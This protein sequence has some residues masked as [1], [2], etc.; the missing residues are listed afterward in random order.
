MFLSNVVQDGLGPLLTLEEKV[1]LSV[2]S[3]S[4]YR[5]L[6]QNVGWWNVIQFNG[7][8]SQIRLNDAQLSSLLVRTGMVA[9]FISL[10]GCTNINGVGLKP[11]MGSTRLK[12]VD[13]RSHRLGYLTK[14]IDCNVSDLTTV[15]HILRSSP[16]VQNVRLYWQRTPKIK[17]LFFEHYDEP[18]RGFM[19][20]LNAR[21]I[22]KYKGRMCYG[23]A[24]T[25]V[26]HDPLRHN[27]ALMACGQ[28]DIVYCGK[29][30][31]SVH[32]MQCSTCEVSYCTNK[33]PQGGCG[34]D[35]P[36]YLTACNRCNAQYCRQGT[37]CQID[38]IMDTT[39][40]SHCNDNNCCE[41]V[42]QCDGKC[43][44]F[45]CKRCTIR[46]SGNPDM[47]TCQNCGDNFCG[48]CG[49]HEGRCSKCIDIMLRY[50][51]DSSD[52]DSEYDDML[53]LFLV[54]EMSLDNS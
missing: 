24:I 11:M 10:H 29:C 5:S 19:E 48:R 32:I 43:G 53:D 49:L 12:F 41:A 54:G 15:L 6:N 40:C 18:I 38:D 51:H 35:S 21:Q 13:L 16:S 3:K 4:L 52:D 34:H 36:S 23:C 46:L 26:S 44:A 25:I 27:L 50:E 8:E 14:H 17:D 2:T 7:D 42:Y 1:R 31:P 22:D 28:C 33:P 39:R 9:Q 45:I 20:E 47:G 37:I 30:E